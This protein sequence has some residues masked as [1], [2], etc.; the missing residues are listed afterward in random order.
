MG[1]GKE[2]AGTGVWIGRGVAPVPNACRGP[3][4]VG[5]EEGAAAETSARAG[6]EAMPGAMRDVLAAV[7][8]GVTVT[9]ARTCP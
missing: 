4:L 5:T 3:D 6:V 8:S 1:P 7:G 9:P 2:V